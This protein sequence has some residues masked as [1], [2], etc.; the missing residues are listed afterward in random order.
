[1]SIT[2]VRGKISQEDREKLEIIC[3]LYLE[4][5]SLLFGENFSYIT[6]DR[7]E[8]NGISFSLSIEQSDGYELRKKA[9]NDMIQRN[10]LEVHWIEYE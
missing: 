2:F 8:F 3:G 4:G 5:V 9:F 7:K 1:M 10:N 6:P